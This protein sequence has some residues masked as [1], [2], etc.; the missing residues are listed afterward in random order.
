MI[1]IACILCTEFSKDYPNAIPDGAMLLRMV[2]LY[3]SPPLVINS[4]MEETFHR[5]RLGRA[6]KGD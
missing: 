4:V 1:R 3:K 2:D 6:E 5:T